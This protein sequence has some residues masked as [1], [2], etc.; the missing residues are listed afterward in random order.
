M[1]L[2]AFRNMRWQT[3]LILILA[4]LMLAACGAK[5]EEEALPEGCDGVTWGSAVEVVEREDEFYAIVQ[6]DYPDSCSTVCGS[7]QE[8]DGDHIN[9]NLYSAR[10]EDLMCSS[11]LTPFVEEVLVDTEDLD[12]GEYTLTINEHHAMTTFSLP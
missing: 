8:V 2:K 4:G 5:D 9:I 11:M 10:P 7:E 6:G 3:V 1:D 12:S